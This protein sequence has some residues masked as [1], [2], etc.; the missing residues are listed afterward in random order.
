[1]IQIHSLEIRYFRSIYFL[2]LTGLHDV[3][4]LSGCNDVGKSNVLKAL[5]LF[6]NNQTEWE[7]PLDFYRD[8]SQRRLS[9]V[10]RD[11]I[12][13]KQFIQVKITFERGDRYKGSLPE[14]FTVTQN[15]NRELIMTTANDLESQFNQGRVPANS[16]P[17]AQASLSRYLNT[18]RYEYVPAIKDRDFFDHMLGRLQDVI[19][20]RKAGRSDIAQPVE[21]L[22]KMIEDRGQELRDEF[23]QVTGVTA[24]IRIPSEFA[25]LF[26]AFYVQTRTGTEELPLDL[27]GD[28]IR[29]RFLPSLLHYI[30]QNSRLY[31][32]WGFEEPEAS[33]EHR[34]ATQL[35][36]EMTQRYSRGAQLF[37]TSHSPAFFAIRQ[38][39][40]PVWRVYLGEDGSKAERVHP[41]T[42]VRPTVLYGILEEELGLMEFQEEQQREFNE[43]MHQVEE[44]RK[45]V[46]EMRLELEREA[47]PALWTEGKWDAQILTVAWSKLFAQET[48][49]FHIRC[50][51]PTDGGTEGGAGGV[52]TL[53]RALE[54]LTR[55]SPPAV[56]LFDRD[57][58]GRKTFDGLNGNFEQA[59]DDKDAKLQTTG[60]A[61]A[62]LL[63][64]VTGREKY[65]EVSNLVL[66]LYFEDQ[67]LE[68]RIAGQGLVLRPSQFQQSIPALDYHK[69]EPTTE[70]HF[71]RICGESKK[72]FAELVVPQ[73]PPE[74]FANFRP[75]FDKVQS[76]IDTLTQMRET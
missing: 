38:P 9:E 21:D 67:Y 55:E 63:P 76:L 46:E 3:N 51:D 41:Q 16:L 5:N 6:F 61:G 62:I 20:E 15:W 54:S 52:Q 39:N 69:E 22:N 44:E 75:L 8:F 47:A 7:T 73:L 42:G 43:R 27:R 59:D 28:G 2:R 72:P 25:E 18:M 74:A 33:L 45:R 30:S 31:H 10:R 56:G 70:P 50:C 37:I 14:R 53:R 29:L 11:T 32:V 13:G 1:M 4:V 58:E 66:E 26:R 12:K 40:A 68:Q 34:L 57:R 23:E 60:T 19:A 17:R 49:P 65:A 24:Q 35:A 71:R 64:V 48:C 36:Q